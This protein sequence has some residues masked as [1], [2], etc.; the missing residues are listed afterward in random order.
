MTGKNSDETVDQPTVNLTN[1][2]TKTPAVITENASVS[3]LLSM[4]ECNVH[5]ERLS[6]MMAV[7]AVVTNSNMTY[8]MRTRSP[9]A[10]TSHRTSD[11][12]HAIIDYSQFMSGNEDDTSPPHKHQA[13]QG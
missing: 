13:A 5:I 8:N 12:P 2:Q 10:E 3:N 6:T 9:K 11:H 1:E 7:P 4:K